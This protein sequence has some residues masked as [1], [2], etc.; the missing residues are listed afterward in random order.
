MPVRPNSLSKNSDGNHLG[1]STDSSGYGTDERTSSKV[2]GIPKANSFGG[3]TQIN[4]KSGP[5]KSYSMNKAG[6]KLGKSTKF[7]FM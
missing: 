4:H 2:R 5:Y 7:H 6:I 3:T 1:S